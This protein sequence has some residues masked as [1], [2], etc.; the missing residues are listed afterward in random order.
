[1]GSMVLAQQYI[2]LWNVNYLVARV[3]LNNGS[4]DI[5]FPSKGKVGV[6]SVRFGGDGNQS[7]RLRRTQIDVDGKRGSCFGYR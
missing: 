5:I 4:V 3:M 1:M 7:Y 6:R 2:S